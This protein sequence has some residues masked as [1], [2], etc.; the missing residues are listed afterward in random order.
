MKK[1]LR[2]LPF[3]LALIF[4]LS[5]IPTAFA[6]T[7]SGTLKSDLPVTLTLT[8]KDKDSEKKLSGVSIEGT[9]GYRWKNKDDNVTE[10]I[11]GITM[12]EGTSNSK[13]VISNELTGF[14]NVM[15]Y[16]DGDYSEVT[17]GFNVNVPDGYKSIDRQSYTASYKTCTEIKK[18]NKI[19]GYE[20][21]KTIQLEK[22]T[23]SAVTSYPLTVQVNFKDQD[24]KAVSGVEIKGTYSFHYCNASG[25]TTYAINGIAPIGDEF[26]EGT[27]R[28]LSNANGVISFKADA[29]GGLSYNPNSSD[30]TYSEIPMGFD[31]YPPS[32][33]TISEDHVNYKVNYKNATEVK[34]SSGNLTGYKYT[35]TIRLTKEEATT[36]TS[37]PA[38]MR[39]VF[40][41]QN[42]NAV[43]GVKIQGSYG[44]R[45]CDKNGNVLMVI[46][47]IHPFGDPEVDGVV[48]SDAA[49]IIEMDVSSFGNLISCS[50]GTY[51]EVTMYFTV[52]A[53]SGYLYSGGAQSFNINY[54]NCNEPNSGPKIYVFSKSI[55]LQDTVNLQKYYGPLTANFKIVDQSGKPVK[56]AQL[57]GQYSY[58][59]VNY[60]GHGHDMSV[61]GICMLGENGSLKSDANGLISFGLNDLDQF[62]YNSAGGYA[63]I[64][65][66]YTITLPSGY[67]GSNLSGTVKITHNDCSETT[68][69]AAHV[70]Y[71]NTFTYTKTFKVQNSNSNPTQK[72]TATPTVKP[73][74]KPTATPTAKPTTKPT[75]TAKPTTAPTQK[76]T[77]V[78]TQK[79]TSVPTQKPTAKPTAVPTSVPTNNPTQRP[80]SGG[81]TVSTTEPPAVS[82]DAPE[83]ESTEASEI[84]EEVKEVEVNIFASEGEAKLDGVQIEIV[85]EE[86]VS[87]YKGYA[88][89]SLRLMPGVYTIKEVD[90]PEGYEAFYN[91]MSFTIPGEEEDLSETVELKH[92]LVATEEPPIETPE[93]TEA[94]SETEPPV[95][96]TEPVS[97]PLIK[98]EEINQPNPFDEEKKSTNWT[99]IA[100]A[101]IIAIA[102]AGAFIILKKVNNRKEY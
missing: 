47:G 26:N 74:N 40:K 95:I 50:D 75:A 46:K 77:S 51:S 13:G 11:K 85:N 99:W 70:N 44:Y 89:M 93:E 55:T 56:N 94:P 101:G 42:G 71:T 4:V 84:V 14:G 65:L 81:N 2:I 23:V 58:K 68:V 30:T 96:E 1:R 67:S 80:S 82:T 8:F 24:N 38:K 34:D 52:E 16:S 66:T 3:V 37:Y 12:F 36:I 20:L 31:I 9:Y 22:E 62:G 33:Y 6:I 29:F 60:D 27:N 102:A 72:P 64:T 7:H 45:T 79:P 88:G 57:T 92:T 18:N 19:V 59:Y 78:P 5:M 28:L 41:D 53:P 90:V 100:I 83:A 17:I 69:S 87:I 15:H 35:A 25:E 32:G 39:L 63:Q 97:D 54:K 21:K 10:T 73:T 98:E 43:Q 49:G 76:P 61:K 86:G 48:A 91:E